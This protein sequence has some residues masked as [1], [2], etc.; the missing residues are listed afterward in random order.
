MGII[1]IVAFLMGV[2]F[3]VYRSSCKKEDE[4]N[5]KTYCIICLISSIPFMCGMMFSRFVR[6][7]IRNKKEKK[8]IV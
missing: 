6:K 5:N 2:A 3:D 7:F 8:S 4:R 1:L